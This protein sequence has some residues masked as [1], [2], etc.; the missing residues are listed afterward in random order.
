MTSGERN[1]DVASSNMVR[2]GFDEQVAGKY[3][4]CDGGSVSADG[5]AAREDFAGILTG[6][7]MEQGDP[8][9]RWYHMVH[10]TKKPPGHVWDSVWCE[11]GFL[12]VEDEP[13]SGDR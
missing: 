10:L 1:G 12:F 11:Q 5:V 7:Y 8:A 2:Y 3:A 4:E 13:R 6:E 9:W